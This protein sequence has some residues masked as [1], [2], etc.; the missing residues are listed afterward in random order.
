[1]EAAREKVGA[2]RAE[3]LLGTEQTLFWAREAGKIMAA[4]AFSAAPLT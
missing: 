1:M 2:E 4:S 3:L